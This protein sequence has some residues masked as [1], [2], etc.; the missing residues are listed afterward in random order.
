MTL[1]MIAAVP[2]IV[3]CL[4]SPAMAQLDVFQTLTNEIGGVEGLD[5]PSGVAISPD[6]GHVYVASVRGNS[7][8]VFRRAEETGTLVFI[9]F[10]TDGIG[11]V[12]G[13]AG[14]EAV[15][16]SPDGKH[17]YATGQNDD[18]V[19]V[20]SRNASTGTLNPLQVVRD[21]VGGV[22]S[23]DAP[24]GLVVSPDGAH[25]YVTSHGDDSVLVFAR[26]AS[27]GLLTPVQVVKD[28]GDVDGLARALGIAIS[29]DG[30]HVYV[31]GSFDNAV[32]AFSRDA[33]TGRLTFVEREK[34]GVGGVN[35][36][37]GAFSVA[38]SRDGKNVYVT[39]HTDNALV[40]FSRDP[41]T[42]ALTF[43]EVHEDGLGG[44]DGLSGPNVVAVS[45]DGVHVY[46]AASGDHSVTDFTRDDATGALTFK[47]IEK[48]GVA[49]LDGLN[50]GFGVVVS[51]DSVD[52]YATGAGEDSLLAFKAPIAA[53]PLLTLTKAGTGTGTVTS[54]PAGI[55]C[56]ATCEARFN[57]F[58][59]VSLRAVPGAGSFFNGM[60]GDADCVDLI[61]DLARNRN[62]I[63]T[64]DLNPT[65]TPP[66]PTAPGAPFG[67]VVTTLE[68]TIVAS[69]M[70]APG[71]STPVGWRDPATSFV[72]ELGSAP[73]LADL[74]AFPVGNVTSASG[75][76]APR[77]YVLAIRGVNTAG[78]GPRSNE[79][80]FSLP[81][82]AAPNASVL[83]SAVAG[84]TVTLTWTPATTCAAISYLLEVTPQS[85][86][87]ATPFVI[88]TA[89]AGT[90]LVRTGVPSGTYRVQVQGGNQFGP[91]PVSNVVTVV[92]P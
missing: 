20:F 21:G 6:G 59:S 26:S 41:L 79:V 50:G 84:N 53:M 27:T 76:L 36:L 34:D 78:T 4:A 74:G 30:A 29:R 35:G 72:G 51:P 85:P 31:T 55:D 1:R 68:N 44:V 18:A 82:Q 16:V 40:V 73:G 83:S 19:V 17:V 75:T 33:S 86:I 28:G 25:V 42:G 22:E 70:S 65:P 87:G 48:D 14:A 9:E 10:A 54:D 67:L 77:S 12:D 63:A 7:V 38:L 11:G 64:F 8:E 66:S 81:C 91:S 2:L 3:A 37:K 90:T 5:E 56:G 80:S 49:G 89:D 43:V 69:W 62:C 61:V 92:V 57:P 32:A 13:L 60:T 45:S 39:G 47:D 46:V 24:R 15:G 88:Q 58:N 52:V 23:L 71:L